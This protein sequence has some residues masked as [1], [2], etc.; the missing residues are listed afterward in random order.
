MRDEHYPQTI[1]RMG[2][3]CRPPYAKAIRTMD[4]DGFEIGCDIRVTNFRAR[5]G[6]YANCLVNYATDSA[7]ALVPPLAVQLAAYLESECRGGIGITP[8]SV[9]LGGMTSSVPS[10]V[11]RSATSSP[12][13]TP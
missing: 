12:G 1:D 8:G 11:S 10:S 5:S 3:R 13:L 7:G 9:G 2:P 4:Y 6:R